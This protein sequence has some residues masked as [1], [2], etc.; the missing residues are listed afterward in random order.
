MFTHALMAVDFSTATDR[1]LEH[2]EQLKK[3]GT[4]RIT[5]LHVVSVHYPGGAGLTHKEDFEGDLDP[6]R[7]ALEAAGF[8]T[9]A[10]ITVGY[11]AHE[12]AN[13]AKQVKA[14]FIVLGSRGHNL[15]RELFLGSVA[16]ETLNRAETP[17]LLMRME[18]NEKGDELQ[19]AHE[20]L[21]D[22]ALFPTD[23]SDNASHAFSALEKLVQSGMKRATLLH[24]QDESRIKPHMAE[25]LEEFNQT[26]KERLQRLRDRLYKSG[27]SDVEMEIRIGSPTQ[28]IIEASRSGEFSLVVM[29]TR[30][31]GFVSSLL[32]GSVSMRTVREAKIPMLLVPAVK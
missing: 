17:V 15:A 16:T 21:L 26:D 1:M 25:K 18:P 6:K 29:G 3:L 11:P 20:S 32:L 12:I 24:V 22:R 5:L 10:E 4:E 28:E 31:R 23:F 8:S 19:L 9:N 13:A 14:D 30:G 2:A 27:A 7:Q